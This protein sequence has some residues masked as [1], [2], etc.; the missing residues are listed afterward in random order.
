MHRRRVIVGMPLLLLLALPAC[1]GGDEVSPLE[2]THLATSDLG[3]V[4]ARTLVIRT[5][6]A[7]AAFWDAHPYPRG[8]VP[9]PP[10]DFERHA[11]A[12]V[13][14]GTKPRCQRLEI[15]SGERQDGVVT[16]RWRIVTFGQSTPSSCIGSDFFDLNLADMVLIPADVQD[17]RFLEEGI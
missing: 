10:V 16:L 17:V 15:A 14:A 1:G 8:A 4:P 5:A 3:P 7:W 2:L 6:A 11:V 9:A 12:G 13:F